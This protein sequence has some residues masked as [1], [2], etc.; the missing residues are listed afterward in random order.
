MESHSDNDHLS[1]RRPV[2][3]RRGITRRRLLGA[4]RAVLGA[5]S[6]GAIGLGA[7]GLR[8]S[9]ARIA[10]ASAPPIEISPPTVGADFQEPREYASKDAF[11]AVKLEAQPASAAGQGRMAYEGSIPGPTLRVRP[12]DNL[13]IALVN[14]LE[15][16]Q[17]NLHVHGFHVSPRANSDNVFVHVMRGQTFNYEYQIP[18]D[19]APGT[20]W[21]H[22]HTHGHSNAQVQ[23]GLA[24]AI[25]IEGGLDELPGIKGK[26]DRVFVLQGPFPDANHQPTYLVNGQIN[27]VITIQPGETQ[28]WRFL[29]AS[30]N[31]FFNLRLAGHKLHQ[32]AADGNPLPNVVT[33]DAM[34]LGP[35]ERGDVLVQGGKAGIY[36]LRSLEWAVDIPSQAQPQFTIASVVSTG[37]PVE[38]TPLPTELIPYDDLSGDEIAQHRVITFQ[39]RSSPPAFA[40]DG[41]AFV[42]GRVDQTVK[43]GT[44]EEWTIRNESPEWHPFH[45][46]VNDFQVMSRNGQALTPHFEDT[47][48]LPPNGEIVMRTR[49]LDFTGKFVYHCHILAHEDAGMMGVIEVVE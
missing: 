41:H 33:T 13:K 2:A 37:E 23:A 15:E 29:N 39:E 45:I 19:H 16:E 48:L 10:N 34:L 28:R 3:A 8:Q 18:E 21:Y 1:P 26:T 49:F 30:A 31:Q 9:T 6:L 38:P 46:H 22:P 11:L 35:G 44:T 25:I 32:I 7:I 42:E 17:T 20:Y 27:P 5:A 12:G 40:I 43:L 36:E 14:S 24:G 4:S 47:A